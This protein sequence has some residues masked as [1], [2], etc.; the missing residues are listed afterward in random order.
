MSDPEFVAKLLFQSITPFLLWCN[1]TSIWKDQRTP[2]K[3]EAN[4]FS[5]FWYFAILAIIAR[6]VSKHVG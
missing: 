5:I 3:V 1:V 2:L 4:Y 6:E